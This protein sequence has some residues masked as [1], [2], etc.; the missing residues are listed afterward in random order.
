MSHFSRNVNR[1]F[2]TLSHA[3]SYNK[4]MAKTTFIL[5]R[6]G[7]THWNAKKKLQGQVDIPLTAKGRREAKA[8]G[9]YLQKLP[10]DVVYSSPLKRAYD[11]AHEIG[12]HQN[13]KPITDPLL[14]ERAFGT[15]EG[16]SYDNLWKEYPRFGWPMALLYPWYA[17]NDAELLI[18]VEKRSAEFVKKA[19]SQHRG[20]TIVVV[21]H[22][23]TLRTLITHLLGMPRSF[24]TD[25]AMKNASI[26][27]IRYEEDAEAELHLLG[28]T[29]HLKEKRLKAQSRR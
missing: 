22:G 3:R 8:V 10:I 2:T 6:H 17:P 15:L 25:Y 9:A 13:R 4:K 19:V 14:L 12:K 21:S 29:A 1:D 23:V 11:T 7:E 18:D 28:S 27:L 16:I 20:K 26:T 5:V 24:N